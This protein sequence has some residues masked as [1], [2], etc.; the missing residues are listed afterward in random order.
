MTKSQKKNIIIVLCSVLVLALSILFTVVVPLK[1]ALA[2][3]VALWYD[4]TLSTKNT[5]TETAVNVSASKVDTTTSV[6]GQEL[7]GVTLSSDTVYHSLVY[8]QNTSNPK[9]DTSGNNVY[10]DGYQMPHSQS[11]TFS[12][13][14]VLDLEEGIGEH[15]TFLTMKEPRIT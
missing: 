7:K 11:L 3:D 15:R 10:V 12:I 5:G 9:Q 6:G 13:N 2:D 14:D 1:R 8:N 4:Y